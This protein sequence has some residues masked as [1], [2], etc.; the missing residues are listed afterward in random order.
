M[1]TQPCFFYHRLL[2]SDWSLFSL[3]YN[4][5]YFSHG[6]PMR[7][8]ITLRLQSGFAPPSAIPHQLHQSATV[9]Y[10]PQLAL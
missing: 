1:S 8:V 5:Y 7:K 3:E 6:H 2:T 4:V 10:G 9:Q